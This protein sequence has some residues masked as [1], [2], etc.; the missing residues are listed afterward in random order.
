MDTGR[1]KKQTQASDLKIPNISS[2]FFQTKISSVRCDHLEGWN[3]EGGREGVARGKKYGDIYIYIYICI[4]D[5][6]CY[7]AESN[8]PL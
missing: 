7:T 2:Y 5:S 8:T 3:R 1:P 4:A 6:L